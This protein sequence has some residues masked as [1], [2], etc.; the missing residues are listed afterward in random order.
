MLVLSRRIGETVVIG[1][2]IKVTVLQIS[3]QQARLGI[4]A[5]TDIRI[6]REEVFQRL[7]VMDPSLPEKSASA[8]L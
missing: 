4:E 6:L 7:Q 5:P 2:R 1:E 8:E 3:S